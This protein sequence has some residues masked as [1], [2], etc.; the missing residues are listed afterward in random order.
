VFR[1]LFD[2]PGEEWVARSRYYES[3]VDAG[4]VGGRSQKWGPEQVIQVFM[5]GDVHVEVDAP[6]VVQEKVAKDVGSLDRLAVLY[7]G[8]VHLWSVVKRILLLGIVFA[9]P[10]GCIL[11]GPEF[12]LP[13]GVQRDAAIAC[14]LVFREPVRT[15]IVVEVVF[16]EENLMH[17]LRCEVIRG[18]E[19]IEERISCVLRVVEM[20]QLEFWK[21][22]VCAS[23]LEEI[24]DLVKGM[25][26]SAGPE[27][28]S[29]SNGQDQQRCADVAELHFDPLSDG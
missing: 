10:V 29:S 11:V 15:I 24:A 3:V 7:V 4:G 9:D 17:D 5:A 2:Q 20:I 23:A 28:E 12:V 8:L 16:V 14:Q 27:G 25:V 19:H 13:V 22:D 1:D 26:L 18:W 21:P 6:V